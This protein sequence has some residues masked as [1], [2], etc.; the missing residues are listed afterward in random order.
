M[1]VIQLVERERA[2]LRAL[3]FASA[4]ALGLVV[5]LV[6]IGAGSWLLGEGRWIVLPR[7]VPVLVWFALLAANGTVFV[8]TS[9]RLRRELA[10]AGV[11]AMIEREQTLRA[12]AVRGV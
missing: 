12:G 10:R 1:T 5:T 7:G 9:R 3:D 8:W 6:I 11:A 4:A 2:R